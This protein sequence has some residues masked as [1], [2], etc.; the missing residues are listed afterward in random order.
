MLLDGRRAV[1]D[2]FAVCA[3]CGGAVV[4]VGPGRWAHGREP[5]AFLTPVDEASVGLSYERFGRRHP[6]AVRPLVRA[7]DV[8]GAV[9]DGAGPAGG[10]LGD[11]RVVPGAGGGPGGGPAADRRMGAGAGLA[12]ALDL[13]ARR[14]ELVARFA[15]AIPAPAALAAV[16]ETGPLV[17]VGAGTGYWAALLRELGADVV[18]TDPAAGANPYHPDGRLWTDVELVD[19]VGAVRRHPGRTLLLCWPP[20][21]DDAASWRCCGRTGARWSATSVATRTGRRGST[22]S[23]R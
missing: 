14:R 10:L 9:G 20:P 2:G 16:A 8:G 6:W 12:Q 5:T 15:W 17:E 4:P 13:P 7:G 19:G 21:E 23:W 11:R 18:A 3:G 22:G 1:V